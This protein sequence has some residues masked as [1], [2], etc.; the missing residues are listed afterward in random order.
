MHGEQVGGD[1]LD[2]LVDRHH[3]RG[4]ETLNDLVGDAGVFRSGEHP[5]A[6]RTR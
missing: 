1:S 6:S 3:R 2:S 4:I 5:G